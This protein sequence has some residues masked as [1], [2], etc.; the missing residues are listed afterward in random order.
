MAV[1]MSESNNYWLADKYDQ[2]KNP[3]KRLPSQLYFGE[4][5]LQNVPMYSNYNLRPFPFSIVHFE[6]FY[7]SAL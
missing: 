2:Q 3:L 6:D 1:F 7:R 5:P 4:M